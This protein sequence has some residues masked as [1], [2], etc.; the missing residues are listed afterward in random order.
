MAQRLGPVHLEDETTP[1]LTIVH[2]PGEAVSFVTGKQGSFLRLME[3]EFGALLF[4]LDFNMDQRLDK[5][6]RLAILGPMRNRRGV[7][8]KVM[9]AV[10]MKCKG[11]YTDGIGAYEDANPGFATD[12]VLIAEEDYSY[13]L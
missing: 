10:E 13:V 8:L 2:V 7:E 9:A 12:T 5:T 6:E 1:E 11:T 4:F 3:E